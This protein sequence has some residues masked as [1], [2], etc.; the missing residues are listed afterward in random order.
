MWDSSKSVD[1]YA[2]EFIDYYYMPVAESFKKYYNAFRS[3]QVYQVEKL[4]LM[5]GMQ[6]FTY[7]SEKNW[8]KGYL[9]SFNDMLDAMIADLE[10]FKTSDPAVYEKYFD[11]LNKE[12]I[13][14]YY[15]YCENYKRY[16][17]E[18]DY[19]ELVEFMRTYCAKYSVNEYREYVSITEKIDGWLS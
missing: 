19:N 2:Y 14:I 1:E 7:I 9:D 4:N 15:L 10:P 12:K 13:W 18:K 6:D 16:F 11:R 17:N 8:P 3:F 5:M